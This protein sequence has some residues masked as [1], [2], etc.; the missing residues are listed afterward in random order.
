MGFKPILTGATSQRVNHFATATPVD[1]RLLKVGVLR[2]AGSCRDPAP[3]E[4]RSALVGE[5]SDLKRSPLSLARATSSRAEGEGT[6]F[7]WIDP[8]LRAG[9]WEEFPLLVVFTTYRCQTT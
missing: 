3:L 2:D 7:F 4:L 9:Y 8:R 5:N 6:R 1:T